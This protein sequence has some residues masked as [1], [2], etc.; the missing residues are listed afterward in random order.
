MKPIKFYNLITLFIVLSTISGAQSNHLSNSKVYEFL[1]RME[2]KGYININHHQKPFTRQVIL[3]KLK[4]LAEA[5]GVRNGENDKNE[6]NGLNGENEKND[7]IVLNA[8]ERAELEYFLK[9]YDTDLIKPDGDVTFFKRNDAGVMRF[10]EYKD[11]R[12]YTNFYFDGGF[13][14][15]QR[16]AGKYELTY[17]NGLSAYGNVGENFSFDLKF[18]DF[19]DKSNIPGLSRKFSED[20][21]YEYGVNRSTTKTFNYDKTDANLTYTWDWGNISL[22]KDRNL[23]GTGYNGRLILS[24]KAPSFP[25]LSAFLS[26]CLPRAHPASRSTRLRSVPTCGSCRLASYGGSVRR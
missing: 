8:V 7:L 22:I 6:K 20:P 19:S 9:E 3:E 12:F 24:D 5:A 4:F 23:W 16:E 13:L 11:S 17:W 21:G 25:H 14:Y 15:A 26:R 18:N 1:D 2:V 10:L